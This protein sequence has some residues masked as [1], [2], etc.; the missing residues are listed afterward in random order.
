MG[1]TLPRLDWL[2]LLA[3]GRPESFCATLLL[4]GDPQLVKA[5]EVLAGADSIDE[6]IAAGKQYDLA[7]LIAPDSTEQVRQ[8]LAQL[9]PGGIIYV[10][11]RRRKGLSARAVERLLAAAQVSQCEQWVMLP[12]TDR[13][14]RYMPV[15][16]PGAWHWYLHTVFIPTGLSARIVGTLLATIAPRRNLLTALAPGVATLG[17]RAAIAGAAVPAP[18]E[19][20]VLITS[21]YDSG[22]RAVLLPFAPGTRWPREVVKIARREEVRDATRQEHIRLLHL[23]ERLPAKLIAALPVP[24]ALTETPRSTSASQDAARGPLMLV[25]GATWPRQPERAERDLREVAEWLAGLHVATAEPLAGGTAGEL[26]LLA[27]LSR[28][29]ALTDLPAP[30]VQLAQAAA[31]T[32]DASNA[33]PSVV[34][35]YDVGPWNIVQGEGSFTLLDWELDSPAGRTGWGPPLVDFVYFANAWYSLATHRQDR[36]GELQAL[37]DAFDRGGSGWQGALLAAQVRAYLACTGLTT[38]AVRPLVVAC[39]LERAVT[40]WSRWDR[41]GEG[42]P[43]LKGLEYLSALAAAGFLDPLRRLPNAPW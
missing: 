9:A 17:S 7:V 27:P 40:A 2:L 18:A 38:D 21:G 35:H 10:E 26:W 28:L 39:W 25:A 41:L 5:L 8:A 30:V 19:P 29:N 24:R 43:D 31:E 3:S 13:P 16:A 36:E 22:S 14:R 34:Q 20:V 33:L 37:L 11:S 32:L 12:D 15:N 23:R 6:H 4:G 42:T 1:S